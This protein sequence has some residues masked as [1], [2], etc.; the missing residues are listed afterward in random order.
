MMMEFLYKTFLKPVLFALDPEFVHDQFTNVGELMGSNVVTRSI[1]GAMYGYH[2]KDISKVVDGITYRTPVLL[3]AGFDYNARLVSILDQI[4]FGGGEFGSVTLRAYEGN[5]KPR[6]TRALQSKSIIVNKGLKNEG[7]DK[8]IERIKR[9]KVYNNFVTGISIARTNDECTSCE[10]AGI[11][12]YAQS[13]EKLVAANV[14]EY[15]TINISCPNAF[16]GETF[17][18]KSRLPKLLARLKQVKHDKPMYI[19]MP[20]NPEWEDFRVLVEIIRDYAFNGVVIGNLNKNYDEVAVRSEFPE[21]YRGGLSG[22]PCWERSNNLISK[23]K[24]TFGD[25]LTII[26]V[27]GIFSPAD[28]LEKMRRGADLV[29]LIT[30]MFM[31]GPHLISNIARAYEKQRYS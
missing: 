24:E 10:D 15:Y 21:N 26:G 1:I 18:E 7:V 12:D 30:G 14:G 2:G 6:L 8:I 4:G 25:D 11:E 9:K 5:T 19:K 17:A 22:R 16:G 3:S 20:I 27:G 28:A 13:L 31:E 23:T 29:Q